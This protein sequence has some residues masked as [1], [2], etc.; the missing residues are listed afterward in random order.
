MF[1]KKLK[2]CKASVVGL[3]TVLLVLGTLSGSVLALSN[4]V[5][6]PVDWS[7]WAQDLQAQGL[8]LGNDSNTETPDYVDGEA[9]ACVSTS[10]IM[11]M[12]Q[13]GESLLAGAT[14]LMTIDE[15]G[16]TGDLSTYGLSEDESLVLVQS[17]TLSTQDLIA[18]LEA[19]PNVSFAEP[20][21]FIPP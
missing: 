16:S 8:S 21:P 3:L 18:Q 1:K 12:S 6:S 14:T 10:P 7:D 4:E 19:L 11:A 17:D 2:K 9:I 5:E 15:G 20:T 13:E